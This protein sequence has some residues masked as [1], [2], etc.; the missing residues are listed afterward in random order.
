MNLPG[1]IKINVENKFNLFCFVIL[2]KSEKNRKLHNESTTDTQHPRNADPDLHDDD[3]Q[4]VL[5]ASS[6]DQAYAVY[7][8]PNVKSERNQKRVFHLHIHAYRGLL[9]IR[10]PLQIGLVV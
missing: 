6:H 8:E 9:S 3:K 10:P 1:R 7:S 5:G 2:A 4:R